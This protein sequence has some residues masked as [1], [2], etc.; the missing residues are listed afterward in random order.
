ML[1]YVL[2]WCAVV[3]TALFLSLTPFWNTMIDL[4][5]NFWPVLVLLLAAL[6]ILRD[7]RRG[8]REDSDTARLD[9]IRDHSLM[10]CPPK[11]GDHFL[12]LQRGEG[13]TATVLGNGS[14]DLRDAIDSALLALA[15]RKAGET[16]TEV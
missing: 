5:K 6:F 4:I 7:A 15:S 11:T 8:E 9:A 16:V 3:L 13:G 1:G 14:P 2:A 10:V 12:I